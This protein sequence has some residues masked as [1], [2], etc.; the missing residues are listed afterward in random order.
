ML[1]FRTRVCS[2]I[3]SKI[4]F[5]RVILSNNRYFITFIY[6]GIGPNFPFH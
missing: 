1:L 2:W 4:L 3:W 6:Q 5:S